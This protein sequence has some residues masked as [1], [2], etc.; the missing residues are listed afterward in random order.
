VRA[1]LHVAVIP[2]RCTDEED[3]HHASRLFNG[4]LL[5]VPRHRRL[6]SLSLPPGA[7]LNQPARATSRR[8]SRARLGHVAASQGVSSAVQGRITATGWKASRSAGTEDTALH[9]RSLDTSGREQQVR[10]SITCRRWLRGR[11]PRRARGGRRGHRFTG[12]GS[13]APIL[14]GKRAPTVVVTPAGFEPAIST[15]KG[16]RPGPG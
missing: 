2:A 12:R 1:Q 9:G 3:G 8:S 10:E 4:V 6:R 15:L 11:P 7:Q 13:Y 5:R 14:P 16:S